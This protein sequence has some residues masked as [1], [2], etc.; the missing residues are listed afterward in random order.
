VYVTLGTFSN[1]LELFGLILEALEGE[2]LEVV[3]TIG[4]DQDPA[5][6]TVRPRNATIEQFIPQHQ[7]LPHCDAVI[8]HAGAGTTF[9]ILAHGLPSVALPQSAD[10]FNIADR[11]SEAGVSETLMPEEVNTETILGAVRR[12][13]ADSSYRASAERLAAEIAVMPGAEEV[14]ESLLDDHPNR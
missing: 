7:I 10:N 14:A 9:G 13:I 1:N 5:E 6:L 8:H 11:L 3:A 4:A 2:D 12:V